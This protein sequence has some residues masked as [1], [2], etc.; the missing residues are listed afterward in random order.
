M[1]LFNKGSFITAFLF[2]LLIGYS[3]QIF[4]DKSQ[5]CSDCSI[6]GLNTRNYCSCNFSN[7]FC[8]NEGYKNYTFL[9]NFLYNYDSCS[10]NNKLNADECGDNE[11][12]IDIGKNYTIKISPNDNDN[13]NMYCVYTIKKIT[14]NNNNLD[15]IIKNE[16]TK[17]IEL[18]LYL[19]LYLTNNDIKIASISNIFGKS[20]IFRIK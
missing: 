18:N 3:T 4:C 14:S 16:G 8:K 10:M 7:A 19:V 1:K 12:N 20:N 9:P 2:K 11:L 13:S 15:I 17:Y 5:N 6:C